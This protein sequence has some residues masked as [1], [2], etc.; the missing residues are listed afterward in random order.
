MSIELGVPDEEIWAAML[1]A[2][3]R[4]RGMDYLRG[5][6]FSALSVFMNSCCA[7]GASTFLDGPQQ[8][9]FL[10]WR[11]RYHALG[12]GIISGNDLVENFQAGPDYECGAL[13]RLAMDGPEGDGEL[14]APPQFKTRRK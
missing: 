3:A 10:A 2:E 1:V 8:R 4:S 7:L 12:R 9:T 14:P 11:D 13:Y 5:H 6:K